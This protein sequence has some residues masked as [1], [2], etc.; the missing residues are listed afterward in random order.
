MF[1]RR[2][3]VAG[4]FAGLCGLQTAG[5][6]AQLRRVS[7]GSNPAGTNFHLVAGGLAKLYQEVLG[8]PSIVR[9]YSGSSVY[10]PM[11]QRG[12]ISLGINSS[13]DS[14]LAYRGIEPFAA[15]LANVR[16][17]FGV[18][19]LG[20]MYWTRANE[21]IHRIEDLRG[22]RVVINYRGLVG[23]D[24]LNR[25]ILAT[26][27]LSEADVTPVTTAG[28]V[29][30]A[31]AVLDGRAD[32]VAMGYRLPI[33]SQMHASIPGGLRFLSMGADEAQLGAGLPG[34][35]VDS[36]EPS[37][38]NVG[39]EEPVRIAVYQTWLNS[40]VHLRNDDVAR[41]VAAAYENWGTLRRDYSVLEPVALPA[42]APIP[43]SHPYHDGAVEFFQ[44]VGLWSDAHAAAQSEVLVLS[45]G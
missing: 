41:L 45:T 3:L 39:I 14:W 37:D 38:S 36:L 13:I 15:P 17:L 26:G 10:L 8:M 16:A 22:R 21:D 5:A 35:R 23:L 30:G 34:A 1:T 33:V 40:G 43:A 7:I 2:A 27:G 4:A 18:Y 25:A 6:L 31:R 12:E 42:L 32:A 11:L 9:P 44:G 19:P 24:R 29:E 20:Y 28:L